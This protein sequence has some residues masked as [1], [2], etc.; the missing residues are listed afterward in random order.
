MRNVS[1]YMTDDGK[2][3]E[4]KRQ[5]EAHEKLVSIG[6]YIED[7]IRIHHVDRTPIGETLRAWEKY[8]AEAV[9]K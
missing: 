8:R 4:D 7:F 1:G 5:A 2:F 9:N 6:K 3:F